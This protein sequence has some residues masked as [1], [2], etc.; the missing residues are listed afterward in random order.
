MGGKTCF[1][2]AQNSL[3]DMIVLFPMTLLILL[4]DRSA[5]FSAHLQQKSSQGTF[6]KLYIKSKALVKYTQ[7]IINYMRIDYLKLR[8]R[9]EC[10]SRSP[11]RMLSKMQWLVT[12]AILWA[13]YVS[14][15][16]ER[17]CNWMNHWRH[18]SS[19]SLVHVTMYLWRKRLRKGL[20]IFSKP[21]MS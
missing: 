1:S 6:A 17:R 2:T 19:F 3:C 4:L 11:W 8:H 18:I 14:Y 7:P 5:F 15:P 21:R 13:I 9:H 10:M 16:T 12:R 20:V